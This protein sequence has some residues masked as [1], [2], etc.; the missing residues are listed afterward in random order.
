MCCPERKGLSITMALSCAPCTSR[1]TSTS[2]IT[3][4]TTVSTFDVGTWSSC[5]T[6]NPAS[7]AL[8][9]KASVAPRNATGTTRY[10]S[11]KS[12]TPTK[13]IEVV[14]TSKLLKS[15]TTGSLSKNSGV[16]PKRRSR[17]ISK[18]ERSAVLSKKATKGSD[19]LLIS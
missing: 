14:L 13:S 15:I 8:W 10:F 5:A 2:R 9:C 11:S 7:C 17:S 16:A 12:H 1:T 19:A 6:N 3:S 18:A 4:C